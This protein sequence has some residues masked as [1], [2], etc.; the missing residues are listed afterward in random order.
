MKK[1]KYLDFYMKCMEDGKM[2]NGGLCGSIGE[3]VI[4]R[5]KPL[6][7]RPGYGDNWYWGFTGESYT[8]SFFLSHSEKNE[9]VYSF[10]PLR[11]NIVLFLAAMNNE[12]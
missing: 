9:I 11:Q 3:G 8:W 5:F 1:E 2:P 4:R 6:E 7:K 12:L 10:S